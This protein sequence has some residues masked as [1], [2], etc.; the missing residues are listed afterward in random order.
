MLTVEVLRNI[1]S[2]IERNVLDAEISR[3]SSFLSEREALKRAH[4]WVEELEVLIAADIQ[5][6]AS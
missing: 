5:N 3:D 6:A 1:T 4:A 2:R